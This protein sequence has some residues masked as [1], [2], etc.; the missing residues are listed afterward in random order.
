MEDIQKRN[1][2]SVPNYMEKAL[3][4]LWPNTFVTLEF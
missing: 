2:E 1:K 3:N 4:K